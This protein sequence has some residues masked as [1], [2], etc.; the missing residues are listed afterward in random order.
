MDRCMCEL[1][2]FIVADAYGTLSLKLLIFFKIDILPTFIRYFSPV[3][4]RPGAGQHYHRELN[5]EISLLADHDVAHGF[6]WRGYAAVERIVG[7]LPN[8]WN[9]D[10][11]SQWA[12]DEYICAPLRTYL[13]HM[14]RQEVRVAVF[15]LTCNKLP[16]ELIEVVVEY[17]LVAEGLDRDD[18]RGPDEDKVTVVEE[19]CNDEVEACRDEDE[20]TI[21]T[22]NLGRD[23]EVYPDM[24]DDKHAV[25][26]EDFQGDHGRYRDEDEHRS[27]WEAY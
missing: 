13:F 25:R 12:N 6:T 11:W 7:R 18:G 8:A 3:C 23:R 5:L 16:R 9:S 21:V 14:A 15:H 24:D 10:T 19:E 2:R 27:T 22:E 1:R 20:Q 26:A 4:G 17:A